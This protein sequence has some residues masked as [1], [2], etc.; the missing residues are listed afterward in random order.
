MTSG[1]KIKL[2]SESGGMTIPAHIV[3]AE[4]V[5]AMDLCSRADRAA[6]AYIGLPLSEL[7]TDIAAGRVRAHQVGAKTLAELRE[8][9]GIRLEGAA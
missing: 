6:S 8:V 5:L 1:R 9:L 2:G 3:S 4:M 7:L